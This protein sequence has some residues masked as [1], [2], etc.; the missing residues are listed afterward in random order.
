[1]VHARV[2]VLCSTMRVLLAVA[3]QEHP[4]GRRVRCHW[5]LQQ[6][7][8]EGKIESCE[9]ITVAVTKD[10]VLGNSQSSQR[11]NNEQKEPPTMAG[12]SPTTV[13]ALLLLFVGLVVALL[14]VTHKDHKVV[15]C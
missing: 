14:G 15:S 11:L 3:N 7:N 13:S 5:L 10:R 2:S 4:D 6:A 12:V 1:M 8:C 9:Q